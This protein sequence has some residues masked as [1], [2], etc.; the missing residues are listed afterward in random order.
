MESI[1]GQDDLGNSMAD[2]L[3][4][5]EYIGQG[6]K[7]SHTNLS[8]SSKTVMERQINEHFST[9]RSWHSSRNLNEP[10]Q[11]NR[12]DFSN[13][14]EVQV[15]NPK[16][17]N[18]LQGSGERDRPLMKYSRAFGESAR[19]QRFP[20]DDVAVEDV[21]EDFDVYENQTPVNQLHRP[22][23]YRY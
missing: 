2:S 3:N 19:R 22:K 11:N 8:V 16:Y 14:D 10:R 9:S 21:E 6:Y 15:L 18:I 1:S 17:E 23:A 4:A 13:Q 7:G 5:V 20:E 12:Y